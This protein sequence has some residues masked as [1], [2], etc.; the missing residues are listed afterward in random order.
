MSR[1]LIS[2]R[3][4]ETSLTFGEAWLPP[5]DGHGRHNHPN[6]EEIL[7]VLSGEGKQMIDDE[8]PF[9]IRPGDTIHVPVG[10]FHATFS[11]SWEP[12]RLL[13]VHA[14]AG[15]EEE[16]RTAEGFRELPAGGIQKWRR[17]EEI[18]GPEG[19]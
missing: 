17:R 16:L 14:P 3:T 19:S 1:W 13:V 8:E 9:A 6:S 18:Q 12:L 2:P 5:G 15:A 11:A 10:V 7:F 4:H